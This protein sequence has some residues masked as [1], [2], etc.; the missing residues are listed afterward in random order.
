MLPYTISSCRVVQCYTAGAVIIVPHRLIALA[1]L[2]A[3]VDSINLGIL[4]DP[5]ALADLAPLAT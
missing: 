1:G 4:A 2:D 3:L 5:V